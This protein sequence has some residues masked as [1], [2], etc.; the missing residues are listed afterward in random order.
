MQIA[1]SLRF[2][3]ARSFAHGATATICAVIGFFL[4]TTSAFATAP[5]MTAVTAD[6]NNNGTVDQI[7]IT[8]DVSTTIIDT[9]AG[10]GLPSLSLGDGCTIPNGLYA[11]VGQLTLTLSG[12]T[13]CTSGNTGITP[14]LSYLQVAGCAT[15]A[16]ICDQAGANQMLTGLP[17]ASA[18][19]GAAPVLQSV[20]VN[21]VGG[22]DDI[23]DLT[24]S[25]P[26]QISN[27]GAF[28][29]SAV[30]SS[31]TFGAMATVKTLEGIATF[32]GLSSMTVGMAVGNYLTLTNGPSSALLRIEF[33]QGNIGSSFNAGSVAP[34]TDTY[35]PVS[36]VTRIKDL[37]GIA[38]NG[39]STPVVATVTSAWDV[40]APTI[41]NTYSCDADG[42]GDVERFQINFSESINDVSNAASI[43][44]GDNDAT[45]DGVGE[46]T[47]STMNTATAGCDGNA[48]DTGANDEKIRIDLATGISG[49][50]TAFVNIPS[51]SGRDMAGNRFVA[52][53]GGGTENDKAKP[54]L[55]GSTPSASATGVAKNAT[56]TL[57]FS[58]SVASITASVS[59]TATLTNSTSMPASTVVFTSSKVSGPNTFTVATAPDSSAN[60]FGGAGTG[61][62]HPL[63]FTVVSSSSSGGGSS[64]TVTHSV[65]VNSPNGGQTYHAGDI[66]SVS[67]TG[68]NAGL[69]N[70]YYSTSNGGTDT[71]I[72][73]NL[74]ESGTYSWT[75][76]N[77][78][79]A[80]AF[81]K[82]VG[83]DNTTL[84][85]LDS[86]DTAF[87]IIGNTALPP[88]TQ[89]PATSTTH[90]AGMGVSPI[91]GL[92]EATNIVTVGDL[93]RGD[94]YPTVY[95][96]DA[97]FLRHPFQDAQTYLTY[98]SSWNIVRTVTGA[99]LS[100]L[101]IGKPMLPKAGVVLV[102]IVSDPRVYAFQTDS[103]TGTTLLRWIPSESVAIALYGASWAD[104]VI[105]I[106]PTLYTQFGH[107]ADMT[108]SVTVDRTIMKTRVHLNQ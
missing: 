3:P 52:V 9:N 88:A 69:V 104:Y 16:A 28:S 92:P 98:N 100:T 13:G 1:T 71:L 17:N 82:A 36:D 106:A 102:K 8:F 79:S 90:P 94:Q 39:S 85:A 95:Y 27:G 60:I 38:V 48:D 87:T 47:A 59:P 30:L 19:D 55:I 56:I 41:V 84:L 67:W 34:T 62:T 43:F 21:N 70:L 80:D 7:T 5:T 75:V 42:D 89:T 20:V 40:T 96:V 50:N 2:A 26:I 6:T 25:E 105:D 66:A 35:T 22:L 91:T 74:G 97:N 63:L 107:G 103:V 73:S 18:V 10:D 51:A 12:L 46:E 81:V 23:L 58:E 72:A 24:Y 11:P 15:E 93:I 31:A 101:T 83:Y 64:G 61:G 86:S 65:I 77:V 45:N 68:S 33:N 37:A 49:T 57:T 54:R 53:S 99:T 14:T 76:P 108:S 78:S 29:T 44:E 4:Y 32:D